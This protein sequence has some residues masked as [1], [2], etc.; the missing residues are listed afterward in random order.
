MPPLPVEINGCEDPGAEESTKNQNAGEDDE[1]KFG[2]EKSMLAQTITIKSQTR[3]RGNHVM[4]SQQPAVQQKYN[5]KESGITCEDPTHQ[6]RQRSYAGNVS[7]IEPDAAEQ[8]GS[9]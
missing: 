8:L 7:Q 6:K 2:N 4:V 9:I 1:R 3:K 5:E